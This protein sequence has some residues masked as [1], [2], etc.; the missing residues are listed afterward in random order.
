MT[1][2]CKGISQRHTSRSERRL[3]LYCMSSGEYHSLSRPK[4]VLV[5]FLLIAE[6]YVFNFLHAVVSV[7]I[8]AALDLMHIAASPWLCGLFREAVII[9]QASSIDRKKSVSP[10]PPQAHFQPFPF[11]GISRWSQ[12]I[13]S[14]LP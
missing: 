9:P 13:I 14:A 3:V 5:A 6:G 12:G 4:L 7:V 11:P 8:H 2:Q 10:L 1:N